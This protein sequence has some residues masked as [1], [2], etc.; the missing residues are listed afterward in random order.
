MRP[1]A[2]TLL[3]GI[4]LAAAASVALALVSQH[5][6]DMQP[7]PWCI[8]QRLIFVVIA[9][10][11]L[12]GLALHGLGRRLAAALVA[13]LAL[14]GIAAALWQNRV[15]AKSESCNLTLAD[16]IVSGL[17]LDAWLPEIFQ[18]R[19]SC[20]DAAVDLLGVPYELW[21]LALFVALGAAAL[22]AL[23]AVPR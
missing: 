21:S 9:L 3:A 15:A 13:A 4:A 16:R 20:I 14:A 8:L 6:F 17:Q 12:L 19:A 5:R 23:S 7:C 2:A 22:R 18:P 11:A 1:G 10:V